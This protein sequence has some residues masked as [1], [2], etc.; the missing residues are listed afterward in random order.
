MAAPGEKRTPRPKLDQLRDDL[1]D[2]TRVL[3]TTILPLSGEESVEDLNHR[4]NECRTAA[5]FK[6]IARSVSTIPRLELCAALEASSS[7][8][9]ILEEL[10]VSFDSVTLHTDSLIV[11]G[12]IRNV[13]KRFS[14]YVSRG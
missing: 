4:I 2:Q 6:G 13:E 9:Q 5:T 1:S 10:T 3:M 8:C 12:Y 11:L 7:A 14:R